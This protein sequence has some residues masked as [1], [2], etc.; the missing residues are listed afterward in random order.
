MSAGEPNPAATPTPCEDTQGDG[1]WMS[2]VCDFYIIYRI[3]KVRC[4]I[5]PFASLLMFSF[6]ITEDKGKLHS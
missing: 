6:A 3:Y 2:M 4:Y 5:I 1:R